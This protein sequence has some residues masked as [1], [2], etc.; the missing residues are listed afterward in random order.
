MHLNDCKKGC[1]S[2]VDRHE[3]LGDGALGQHFFEMLMND[4][5]FD[6][7]PIILEPPDPTRWPQEIQGL[8]S[9]ER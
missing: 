2:R 8:R 5:R 4:S 1:G 6:D 3:S 9:L 7:I